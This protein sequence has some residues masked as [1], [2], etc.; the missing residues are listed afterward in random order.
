MSPA[1]PTWDQV[2][3][4]PDG[5]WIAY[6]AGSPIGVSV[7]SFP[8]LSSRRQV[9]VGGGFQPQWSRD[10]KE[11]FYVSLSGKLMS[12]AFRKKVAGNSFEAEAPKPLMDLNVLNRFWTEY[13]VSADGRRILAIQA[14][15]STP[16]NQIHVILNWPALLRR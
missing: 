15:D 16:V 14:V 8:S 1:W 2:Q 13:Q 10:G 9:S 6:N 3:F 4:S 12:V 5:R 11:L 7:S